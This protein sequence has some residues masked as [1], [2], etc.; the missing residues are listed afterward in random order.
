MNYA[1]MSNAEVARRLDALMLSDDRERGR[2]LDDL[3]GP[4]NWVFDPAMD[5]WVMKDRKVPGAFVIWRRDLSWQQYVPRVK[6]DGSRRFAALQKAMR[7]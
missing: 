2:L 4:G 3:V 5:H 6:R 7:T 1:K